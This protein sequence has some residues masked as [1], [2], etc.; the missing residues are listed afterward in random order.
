[1]SFHQTNRD[2]KFGPFD[3]GEEVGTE[4]RARERE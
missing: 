1:M 3:V 2:E 4:K